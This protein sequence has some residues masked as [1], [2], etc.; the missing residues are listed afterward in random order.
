MES[1][2]HPLHSSDDDRNVTADT[3]NGC[4]IADVEKRDTRE[5]KA[6]TIKSKS[7]K[8]VMMMNPMA[9]NTSDED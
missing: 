5:S 3:S 9:D 4:E 7:K 1:F 2:N 6:T 8:G